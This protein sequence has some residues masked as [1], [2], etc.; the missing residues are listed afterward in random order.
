LRT[1]RHKPGR[2]EPAAIVAWAGGFIVA[3][4]VAGIVFIMA[5]PDAPA[6]FLRPEDPLVAADGALVFSGD[7]YYAR[8]EEAV[9]LYRTGYVRFLVFSG[10][11]GPGD[12]AASMAT[13]ALSEGV[14]PGALLL[15]SRARST[16]ENVLFARW[17][18]AR[19]DIHTLILVTTPYHQRRAY[20]V[21]RHLLSGM[22][23]IN[24][25]IQTWYW[26]PR[27]WWQSPA[28]RAAILGEY[29]KIAGYLLLGRI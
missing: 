11:G 26:R 21:A 7:P 3:L 9:R 14:P 24:H 18:L 19:H 29:L 2:L 12:S 5:Y 6:T 17:L 8:T 27:S 23:L 22:V 25:P 1:A 20:L 10:A 15:D 13:I 4:L 28:L 16:Y